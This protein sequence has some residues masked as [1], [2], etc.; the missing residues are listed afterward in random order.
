MD[1]IRAEVATA[2]IGIASVLNNKESSTMHFLG[3]S[4]SLRK[5]SLNSMLL[6]ATLRLVPNGVT[7]SVYPG[8]GD[9]PLFNPDI[10]ASDPLPVATLR[11]A[12]I[13]ADAII[14]ASPEYAHGVTGVI[15]NA[16]DWMVST[17]AF[18]NKPVALFNASPVSTYAQPALREIVGVMSPRVVDEAAIAIWI[19]GS[20]LNE[21]GIVAHAEMSATIRDAL[22]KLRDA[23]V[24]FQEQ[25]RL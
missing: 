12:I 24:N 13:D 5:A 18:I 6:R 15:K 21:D 10:E 25:D 20:K 16:L 23:V 8:L 17:E 9:L 4:G 14:I 11:K 1:R 7:M 3:I 19:R 22:V 2:N